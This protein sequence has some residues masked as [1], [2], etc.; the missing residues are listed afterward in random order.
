MGTRGR[1]DSPWRTDTREFYREPVGAIRPG[2]WFPGVERPH[3]KIHLP[4][5]VRIGGA[6]DIAVVRRWEGIHIRRNLVAAHVQAC[7]CPGRVMIDEVHM[8]EEPAVLASCHET[9]VRVVTTVGKRF[10]R[11]DESPTGREVAWAR[12]HV[13]V[14]GGAPERQQAHQ[15]STR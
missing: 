2:A 5:K 14:Y 1:W 6:A 11:D 4:E 3:S 13:S 7:E 15:Q 12:N 8:T 10:I 9:K